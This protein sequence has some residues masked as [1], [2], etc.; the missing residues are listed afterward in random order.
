MFQMYWVK[1][2]SDLSYTCVGPCLLFISE[3][4]VKLYKIDGYN[5]KQKS[6]L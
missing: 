5:F 6:V 4:M 2:L 3:L 1:L